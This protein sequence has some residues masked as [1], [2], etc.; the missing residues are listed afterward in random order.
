M[1][2][3]SLNFSKS[4]AV[5]ELKLSRQFTHISTHIL[6]GHA[7]S[8][9]SSSSPLKNVCE[10]LQRLLQPIARKKDLISMYRGPVVI[11]L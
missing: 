8:P 6:L 5:P 1:V 2:I 10:R 3:F 7:I 11:G 9:H 4:T